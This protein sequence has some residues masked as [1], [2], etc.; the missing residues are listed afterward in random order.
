M[1]GTSSE[2]RENPHISDEEFEPDQSAVI[3]DFVTRIK[4]LE[5]K[6]SIMNDAEIKRAQTITT[7]TNR[8]I[9]KTLRGQTITT[10]RLQ[11]STVWFDKF[12]DLLTSR[13]GNW[14]KLPGL[15]ENR[16]KVTI[17]SQK[18]FINSLSTHPSKNSQTPL[19]NI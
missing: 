12:K 14:E 1:A 17:K 15:I 16:G 10:T 8:S 5:D 11:C 18:E 19:H 6:L 9:S 13:H 3:K 2:H 7:R 4:E